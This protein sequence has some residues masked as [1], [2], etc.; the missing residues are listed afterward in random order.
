MLDLLLLKL[1]VLLLFPEL[2]FKAV[3]WDFWISQ[4]HSSLMRQTLV[5]DKQRWG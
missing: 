2:D 5:H 3:W 1:M 4:P